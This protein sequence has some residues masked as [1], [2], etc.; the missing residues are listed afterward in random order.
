MALA[1]GTEDPGAAGLAA[2]LPAAVRARIGAAMSAATTFEPLGEERVN[3]LHFNLDP[4]LTTIKWIASRHPAE[5][6][7]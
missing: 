3:E 1:A 5:C 4:A 7:T 2:R 6:A